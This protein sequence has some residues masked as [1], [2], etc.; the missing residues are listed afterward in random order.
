VSLEQP[1]NVAPV[2]FQSS[3]RVVL[4]EVHGDDRAVGLVPRES[5]AGAPPPITGAAMSSAPPTSTYGIGAAT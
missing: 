5:P 3:V 2:S 4:I 1:F